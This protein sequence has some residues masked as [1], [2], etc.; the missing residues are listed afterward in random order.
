MY[1]YIYIIIKSRLLFLGYKP[2]LTEIIF[3]IQIYNH[4]S[5]T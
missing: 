5:S 1:M 4:Y 2:Y 3:Y